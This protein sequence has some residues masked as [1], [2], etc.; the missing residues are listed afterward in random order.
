LS[1]RRRS[2]SRNTRP[3]SVKIPISF[4]HARERSTRRSVD[5][6]A[7][8]IPA[9][10]LVPRPPAM[11]R[12]P[13]CDFRM[14]NA[15]QRDAAKSLSSFSLSL[16]LSLAISRVGT[17]EEKGR[18][19]GSRR[20]RSDISLSLS[21]EST[22]R[23]RRGEKV[24]NAGG[25][26]VSIIINGPRFDH[27]RPS[28]RDRKADLDAK[29]YISA[30]CARETPCPQAAPHGATNVNVRISRRGVPQ[31][32]ED[33]SLFL[34]EVRKHDLHG[35]RGK[36]ACLRKVHRFLSRKNDSSI[37]DRYTFIH[38]KITQKNML[39]LQLE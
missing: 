25:K 14:D 38:G 20:Q 33:R 9:S 30:S 16:S 32:R 4:L 22:M 17:R 31:E 21:D 3:R 8:D 15:F 5:F 34:R 19:T 37:E 11:Y 1:S 23:E 28:L 27:Y 2:I 24:A 7:V 13:P 6:F 12:R 10:I 29:S 35:V 26:R 39:L 18:K 36:T